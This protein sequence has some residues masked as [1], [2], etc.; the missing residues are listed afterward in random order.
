[1]LAAFFAIVLIS[2]F[3]V[4]NSDNFSNSLACAKD[5]EFRNEEY[6]GRLMKKYI[7]PSNH[8]LKTLIIDGNRTL[9]LAR[10]TSDFYDFVQKND[11]I[12]KEKSSNSIVLYR[13]NKMQKFR[14]YFGCDI[15]TTNE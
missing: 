4:T 5:E 10:D 6:K 11:S 8:G 2:I 1:M 7:D 3:V 14:I 13:T 9:V 12:V 15:V